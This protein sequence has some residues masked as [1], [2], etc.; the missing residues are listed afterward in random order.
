MRFIKR[1]G[2]LVPWALSVALL[3]GTTAQ[4]AAHTPALDGLIETLG[5][6]VDAFTAYLGGL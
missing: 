2:W 5:A 3:L 4:A 1:L 6:M